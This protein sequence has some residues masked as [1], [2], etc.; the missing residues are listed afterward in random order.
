M[1]AT[2]PNLQFTRVTFSFGFV[3]P[4]LLVPLLAFIAGFVWEFRRV[5]RIR[6]R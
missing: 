3:E 1:G 6:S 5:K 2:I 4:L